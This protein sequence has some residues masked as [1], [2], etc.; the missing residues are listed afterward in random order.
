MAEVVACN[1][2][3]RQ[4]FGEEAARTAMA[5][6][7]TGFDS[8]SQVKNDTELQNVSTIQWTP[9]STPTPIQ[10]MGV[11]Q[12]SFHIFVAKQ[13]LNRANVVAIFQQMGCKAVAKRV[14][15]YPLLNS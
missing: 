7:A 6:N 14:K 15:T 3:H 8:P 11:H 10:H 4:I 1:D 9:H 12:S 5:S 13:F 2:R